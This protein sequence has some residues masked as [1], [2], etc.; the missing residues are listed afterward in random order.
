M[1]YDAI[2]V[3]VGGAGSAA[4]YHLARRGASVLGLDRFAPGHDR[5]SSH[6][7]TRVI[8][9]AY[10]EAP[11]YVPLLA[12]AHELWADLGRAYGRP[13][14]FG[15][16]LV[17]IGPER[18][19]LLAHIQESARRHGIAVEKLAAAEA[20]RRYPG[21]HVPDTMAAVVERFAG[22]LMVEEC[23]RAHVELARRL[24]SEIRSGE[25]VLGWQAEGGG[26]TVTT[27]ADRYTARR[28][29]LTPG[30][31][32]HDLLRGLGI[33]FDA[34]RKTVL[35]YEAP[36]D[37]YAAAAG[38]PALVVETPTGAFYAVPKVDAL[39][40]KAAERTGGTPVGDPLAVDR[41]IHQR[42]R[43]PVERFLS[44]YLPRVTHRLLHHIV[45]VYP[46]SPDGHLVVDRYPGHPQ[47]A[48]AAGLSGHG[49]KF[50]SVLGEILAQLVL[51]GATPHPVGFLSVTRETL[52]GDHSL[53]SRTAHG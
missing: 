26:V 19:R 46:M 34:L 11:D 20:M 18:G 12:R 37:L 16:G 10:Q 47:V 4:L 33:P 23:I 9:M 45:C 5:G 17:E 43:R 38:C 25:T 1:T 22:Y 50:T 13:L 27:D 14:Q 29:V 44:E 30:A 24:G 49:F 36:D 35:W 40:L 2:V 21:L 28:L 48:F 3:G 53:R 52:R 6:G 8:R 31:W 42:D 41:A 32:A 15:T 39:G 7:E 51:D